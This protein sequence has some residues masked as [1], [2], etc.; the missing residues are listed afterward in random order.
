MISVTQRKP[1]VMRG[2]T[3][4]LVFWV[5]GETATYFYR[6]GFLERHRHHPFRALGDG[7]GS[8]T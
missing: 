6:P 7:A 2:F 1:G 8:P 4:R 5:V 3:A